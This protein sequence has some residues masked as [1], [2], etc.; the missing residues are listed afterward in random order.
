MGNRRLIFVIFCTTLVV[1]FCY[2]IAG[3]TTST[4]SSNLKE[5]FSAEPSKLDQ[6]I[7]R[8][9]GIEGKFLDQYERIQNLQ[10]LNFALISTTF[11]IGLLGLIWQ[12]FE[13]R[14]H[15]AI[16]IGAFVVMFVLSIGINFVGAEVKTHE[17]RINR[18][19][20]LLWISD[21]E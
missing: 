2:Q 10:I 17:D 8:L 9:E 1:L 11:L 16:T 15:R 14:H 21:D 13:L 7:E 20:F 3:S 4:I 19:I 12:T 6:A 5:I 18:D